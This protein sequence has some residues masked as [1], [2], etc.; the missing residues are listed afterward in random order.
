MRE[1]NKEELEERGK[2]KLVLKLMKM[3]THSSN[4]NSK[5]VKTW[6]GYL[7]IKLMS[8]FRFPI[9]LLKVQTGDPQK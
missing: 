1:N 2:Y 9:L 7:E 6:T 4:Y 5:L 3:S 8:G